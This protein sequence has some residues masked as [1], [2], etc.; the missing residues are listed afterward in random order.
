M[1]SSGLYSD[2]IHFPLALTHKGFVEVNFVALKEITYFL[3]H[4]DGIV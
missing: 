3:T 1:V 2:L 4:E